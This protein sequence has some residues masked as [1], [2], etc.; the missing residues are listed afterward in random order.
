M[1]RVGRSRTVPPFNRP[2]PSVCFRRSDQWQWVLGA[3]RVFFSALLAAGLAR[4]DLVVPLEPPDGATNVSPDTRLAVWLDIGLLS[5]TNVR[6]YV[7]PAVP[8]HDF[9]IA[10]LPDTQCYT[11][12]F[13]GGTMAMF[14]SQIRW[15]LENR[16]RSNIV[17]VA[18]LGDIVDRGDLEEWEWWNAT[19]ALYQL[20]DPLLTGLPDGMPY[21]VALGNHDGSRAGGYVNYAR[22]RQDSVFYN[23]YF[24]VERFRTRPWYG[25]HFGQNNNNHYTLFSAG[26][27]DFIVLTLEF[28]AGTNAS[29]MAWAR[30]VLAQHADRLA[31]LVSHSLLYAQ[32]V[33]NTDFRQRWW[34]PE[35]QIIYEAMKTSSNLF[36]MLCG[37][38]PVTG[39]RI[40]T[41]EGRKIITVLSDFENLSGG[42]GW[43]RLFRF[44][45][46][47]NEIRVRTFSPW[48]NRFEDSPPHD[49]TFFVDL[50]GFRVIGLQTN[51]TAPVVMSPPMSQWP[52]RAANQAWEWFAE[53]EAGGRSF[54]TPVRSFQVASTVTN[55]VPS[56]PLILA[57]QRLL[58]GR[59]VLVWQSVGGRRYRVEYSD[60]DDNGSFNGTFREIV[61]SQLEETDAG[62]PGLPGFMVYVDDGRD[63]GG[64]PRAGARYYRVRV[65]P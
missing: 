32:G 25:G 50:G 52:I 1:T 6:F 13:N 38:D 44:S 55:P 12:Q 41:H 20:E 51:V 27:L 40:D 39:Y 26:G 48:L 24:G 33:G 61:R 2:P 53:V 63:T 65:V 10:A 11:R 64:P 46:A 28:A 16:E 37:H 7:R 58:D 42:S 30:D 22:F 56:A 45:P 36:L 9:T 60:G 19:N 18:H 5:G 31:I 17:F 35:G 49:F 29:V 21:T 43:M 8:R 34:S 47:R 14:L 15:I 62:P 54:R 3:W 23:R 4:A 59:F 57:L